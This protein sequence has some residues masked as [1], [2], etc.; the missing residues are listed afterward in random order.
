MKK[1]WFATLL[2]VLSLSAFAQERPGYSLYMLHQPLV[3]PAAM[4][5]FDRFNLVSMFSSQLTG[6][7]G[8]PMTG[9]LDF[10][11]PIGRTGFSIGGGLIFDK[12]GYTDKTLLNLNFGY[13][14]TLNP[15]NYLS[16]GLGISTE[17]MNTRLSQGNVNDPNDP[18]VME[19]MRNSFLPNARAGVYYF[20]NN[21]YVGFSV[22]NFMSYSIA[23]SGT[24]RAIVNSD[25]KNMHFY[26][27]SGFNINM[28]KNWKFQPSLLVKQI[29]GSP[30]QFD[31]NTRF[32][33]RD[34]IGFGV[35]Y[36]TLSTFLVFAN[37][38]INNTVTIAYGSAIGVDYG[39]TANYHSHEVMLAFK[40]KKAKQIIPVNVP[41]F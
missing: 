20:R 31:I 10:V 11:A 30:M 26:L 37:Y 21:F 27:N 12:A 1:I 16:F 39:K 22:G 2:L 29:A 35:S 23:N 15:K 19:D 36:R 6:F 28:G 32:L 4:G 17:Y 34:K 25:P 8:A 18:I 9:T 3:N 38:T 41:R 7:K 40:V 13:R 33:F 24:P 5:T 14:V